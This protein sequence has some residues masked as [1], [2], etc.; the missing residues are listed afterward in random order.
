VPL[1]PGNDVTLLK[2]AAQNYP[3]WLAAI[4]VAQRT[5]HFE[6]YIIHDDEIGEQLLARRP[7]PARGAGAAHLRLAG[8]GRRDQPIL[9]AA[10]GGR[11]GVRRFNPPSLASA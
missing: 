5:I 2:D 11:R 10:A 7:G 4:E 1:V 8:R 3:A 9:A 6:S